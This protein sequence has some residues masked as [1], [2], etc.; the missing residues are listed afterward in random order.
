MYSQFKSLTNIL[1]CYLKMV[2]TLKFE[3]FKLPNLNFSDYQDIVLKINLLEV[4][5]LKNPGFKQVMHSD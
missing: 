4:N 5:K 3:N 2:N 1:T